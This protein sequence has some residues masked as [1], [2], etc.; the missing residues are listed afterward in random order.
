MA[1]HTFTPGN[2]GEWAWHERNVINIMMNVGRKT[3]MSKV[4][5]CIIVCAHAK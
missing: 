1:T 5:V 4:L 3:S 2:W